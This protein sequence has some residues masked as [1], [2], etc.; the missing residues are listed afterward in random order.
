MSRKTVYRIL[1]VSAIGVLLLASLSCKVISDLGSSVVNTQVEQLITQIPTDIGSIVTDMVPTDLGSMITEI[2][3][4]DI[5]SIVTEIGGIFD[6]TPGAKPTDIPV[7]TE[8]AMELQSSESEVMYFTSLEF[9]KVVDFYQQEMPKNGWTK[10]AAESKTSDSEATLVFTKGN[11][12]AKVTITDMMIQTSVS[13]TI[14][15][16]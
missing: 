9:Q 16:Q 1:W 8:G 10:V 11:R 15:T 4:T 14:T 7:V 2:V 12:K 13:I 5:G 6:Q 3:P